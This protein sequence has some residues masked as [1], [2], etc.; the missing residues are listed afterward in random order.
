[1]TAQVTAGRLH[2]D[3]LS[4]NPEDKFMHRLS[5]RRSFLLASMVVALGLPLFGGGGERGALF[6]ADAYIEHVKKL[7]S[8]EWQGRRPGSDGMAHAEEYIAEHFK[9]CGLKPGGDDG[10]YFQ[11]F[12]LRRIKKFDPAE[13][14]M[15]LGGVGR[16]L[17]IEKDWMP[18]GFTQ[19]GS[20]DDAPIAFVGF[21][22]DAAEEGYT[23]FV[24]IDVSGKVLLMFRGEPKSD[25]KDAKIG[26]SSTSTHA[27]FSKKAI[28][29]A[30]KGAKGI[31]I[32]NAY[33]PD[34]A[35]DAQ[36]ALMAWADN[37]SSRTY[38]LPFVQ[39]TRATA[40]AILAAAN[41][42]TLRELQKQIESTRKAASAD[43]AGVKLTASLGVKYGQARNCIGVLPGA[44]APDE[45]IV[46]GGHHD[47]LGFVS[48]QFGR[49]GGGKPQIH[50]G[51]DDNAS[52]TS[53]VLELARVISAGTRPRR[54]I[55]FM[56]FS[57][58]E[59]GLLGSAHYV[60]NPTVDL[61]QI[62]AMINL[63]MIGR[64]GLDAF[65]IYGITTATEFEA[66]V[67]AKA[68][69]LGVEYKASSMNGPFAGSSDHYSFYK[70]GIPVLFAF[71]GT[72]PQYHKPE[73]DWERI[74][75]T[76]AAKVLTMFHSF[77]LQ[78]ANME[79]G[80][81]PIEKRDPPRD[82]SIAPDSP[83]SAPSGD[84]QARQERGA[85]PMP[86][87]RLGIQPDYGDNGVGVLVG[88][89]IEGG[90]AAKGGMKD[91][92]RI[93]KIAGSD[94]GDI[95]AYMRQMR[96]F[97]VGDEIEIVV[98]R[99]NAGAIEKVSLKITLA[100]REEPR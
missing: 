75:A 91:G 26:G 16:G 34:E 33:K 65:E 80:P 3:Q 96:E 15:S 98:E 62:K 95:Q 11:N 24:D 77:A 14:T 55:I 39:V 58:E 41:K 37:D 44:A 9:A 21:G 53:G 70:A 5:F 92:D 90:S 49:S 94:I 79:S 2:S 42:P 17:A 100:G 71:T 84:E 85:N 22:I 51:A 57:A 27:T 56:T 76:G 23:D 93:L 40:N 97:K 4:R 38:R 45:Y 32:V 7:A 30:D 52:G 63:D 18:L 64:L 12:E 83:A 43:L 10:T 29:A 36:D 54:S 81:T 78:V 73:D 31:L 67:D 68:R 48:P 46:I 87:V 47:H 20:L 1:M 60:K 25:D 28:V 35:D 59:M 19:P 88:S 89:V 82:G 50:N 86:R 8:D 99:K 13:A 66:M 69:E 72:H 74:D 61:K 6:S